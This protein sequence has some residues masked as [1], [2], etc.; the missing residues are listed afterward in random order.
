[1]WLVSRMLAL[2][3]RPVFVQDDLRTLI[4][5]VFDVDKDGVVSLDGNTLLTRHKR[6]ISTLTPTYLCAEFT[7]G[8]KKLNA[9]LPIEQRYRDSDAGIA[10]V[11]YPSVW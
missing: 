10:R 2:V 3:L 4:F 9:S 11:V 5:R 7:T 6:S 1:L 8:L